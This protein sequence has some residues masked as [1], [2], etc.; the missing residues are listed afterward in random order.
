M[1]IKVHTE[2]EKWLTNWCVLFAYFHDIDLIISL[3]RTAVI[4]AGMTDDYLRRRNGEDFQ[5]IHS[6]VKPV[7]K[8]TL[9]VMV[10]QEQLMQIAV[11]AG[12]FTPQESDNFRKATKLK[13]AAHKTAQCGFINRVETIAA[14]ELAAS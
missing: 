5:Y 12:G 6:I 11:V 7:L 3:Y 13:N 2:E 10:Y 14:M 4:K 1:L 9:G 8:D